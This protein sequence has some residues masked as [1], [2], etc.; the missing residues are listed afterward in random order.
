MHCSCVQ[1]ASKSLAVALLTSSTKN[2]FIGVVL[3]FAKKINCN[4]LL[5][6]AYVGEA[7]LVELALLVAARTR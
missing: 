7:L 4:A 6:Q 2:L 5:P 1:S 3:G